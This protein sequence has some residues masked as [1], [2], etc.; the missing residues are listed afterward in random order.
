MVLA[1]YSPCN[2]AQPPSFAD[3]AAG[4]SHGIPSAHLQQTTP[5]LLTKD[6]NRS[7][8]SLHPSAQSS[9]TSIAR[10]WLANSQAF[11]LRLKLSSISSPSWRT[12]ISPPLSPQPKLLPSQANRSQRHRLPAC[13]Q[14]KTYPSKSPYPPQHKQLSLNDLKPQDPQMGKNQQQPIATTRKS[15]PIQNQ[16]RLSVL[17][18]HTSVC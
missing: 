17:S 1:Q 18:L 13:L 10:L 7:P 3:F 4:M 9:P 2:S 14:L 5:P 15:T 11:Q 16:P 12:F 6:Q 8:N